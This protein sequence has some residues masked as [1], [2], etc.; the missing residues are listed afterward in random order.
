MINAKDE[1]RYLLLMKLLDRMASAGFLTDEEL[2]AARKLAAE[3]YHPITVW[4]L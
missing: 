2:S 4:E 1:L 3:K